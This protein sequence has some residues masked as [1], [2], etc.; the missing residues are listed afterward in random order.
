[1]TPHDNQ[2]TQNSKCTECI[3]HQ[4][5]GKKDVLMII[6]FLMANTEV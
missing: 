4:N 2:K 1:M 3:Q 6:K 5:K